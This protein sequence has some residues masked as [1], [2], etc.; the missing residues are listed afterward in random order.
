M[1]HVIKGSGYIAVDQTDVC[2]LVDK[3]DFE[4]VIASECDNKLC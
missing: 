2:G 1:P 4:Q 3:M